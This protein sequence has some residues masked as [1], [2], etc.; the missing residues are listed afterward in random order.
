MAG[1]ALGLIFALLV[2][3]SAQIKLG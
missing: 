1:F 3:A 2:R